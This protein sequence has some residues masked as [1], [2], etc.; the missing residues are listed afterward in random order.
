MDKHAYLIMAHHRIDV[1]QKLINAL[2]D[3]RNDIFIHIDKK[4]KEDIRHLYSIKSKIYFIDRKDI[5]WGGPSQVYCEMDLIQKAIDNNNYE[6]LHLLTGV[7]YPIKTQDYIH[8][9]FKRNKGKEFVG[10]SN[11]VIDDRVKYKYIFNEIGKSSNIL[12]KILGQIRKLYV[13]IQ[14]KLKINKFE[15]YNM[16]CKK[17]LAYFSITGSF[18]NYIIDNRKIIESFIQD[19]ICGDE[20]FIQTILYNSNYKDNIY[21]LKDELNGCL[22][23]VPWDSSDL[24]YRKGFNIDKKDISKIIN[25]KF[26]YAFKFEDK[27]ALNNINEIEKKLKLR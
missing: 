14:K 9:F 27:N 12:K 25:S 13:F 15:K 19:S 7:T 21:D 24:G 10:F 23:I 1:L 5:A 16:I 17:G 6:Y 26:L 3:N 8:E 18:A 22:R 2:D 4:C 20:I 11:N